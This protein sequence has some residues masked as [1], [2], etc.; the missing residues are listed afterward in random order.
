MPLLSYGEQDDHKLDEAT[1][2]NSWKGKLHKDTPNAGHFQDWSSLLDSGPIQFHEQAETSE[3]VRIA[4]A[5]RPEN[6]SALQ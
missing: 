1:L 4:F 5:W 2:L 6:V 3:F